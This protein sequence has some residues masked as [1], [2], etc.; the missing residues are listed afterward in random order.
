MAGTARFLALSDV[1]E[2]NISLSQTSVLCWPGPPICRGIQIGGRRQGRVG[3]N[4]LEPYITQTHERTAASLR[5][6][7]PDPLADPEMIPAAQSQAGRWGQSEPTS[8]LHRPLPG[9]TPQQVVS[10]LIY[11]VR[12][13]P[14]RT[15]VRPVLDLHGMCGQPAVGKSDR[16]DHQVLTGHDRGPAHRLGTNLSGW[17][18]SNGPSS[19]CPFG[20]G[21]HRAGAER[22]RLR[23]G[24]GND[25]ERHRNPAR[26]GTTTVTPHLPQPNG[27]GC[28]PTSWFADLTASKDGLAPTPS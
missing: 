3:R 17:D 24:A 5:D 22:P 12:S 27:P 1:A 20:G 19:G 9:L 28:G 2:L 15:D 14:T 23:H 21:D 11:R 25:F 7:P 10:Q 6:L 26:G 8:Q 18:V 13:G 16:L 4:R